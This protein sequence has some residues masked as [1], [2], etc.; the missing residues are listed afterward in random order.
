M[1]CKRTLAPYHV[2]C[3][4]LSWLRDFNSRPALLLSIIII[5]TWLNKKQ[6][7]C[8]LRTGQYLSCRALIFH[9]FLS[10]SSR[11]FYIINSLFNVVLYSID[12]LSL[13]SDQIK[14]LQE[15]LTSSKINLSEAATEG[16]KFSRRKSIRRQNMTAVDSINK[17]NK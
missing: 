16:Q 9:G 3:T 13:H 5:T 17:L 11:S 2:I 15:F 10:V 12:H 14:I 8:S 4:S 6:R 7:T 1:H